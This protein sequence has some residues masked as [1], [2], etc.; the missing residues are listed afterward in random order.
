MPF[1]RLLLPLI[2]GIL[3]AVFLK[4]DMGLFVVC[5][6]LG[7]VGMLF[8]LNVNDFRIS[9]RLKYFQA[10]LVF[11]M[12]LGAG[13]MLTLES[14]SKDNPQHFAQ[15]NDGQWMIGVLEESLTEKKRSFRTVLSIKQVKSMGEWRPALGN[16]LVYLSKDSLAGNLERGDKLLVQAK[17]TELEEPANP[18]EFN[19]KRF[20][21]FR[22]IYH[23]QFIKS[24]GWM[25]LEK[26]PNIFTYAERA[27]TLL[28]AQLKNEGLGDDEMAIASALLLGKKDQLSAE[29]MHAYAGAG[30]MHVLAVSGLHMGI[31]F[32]F[33]SKVLK[34][35]RQLPRGV[36]IE[37]VLILIVMWGFAFITG[38]SPS[39]VRASTMFTAIAMARL[40]KRTSDIYN[41]IAA[42]AFVLLLFNPFYI[43][44]VG[45]QLSYLA[46]VGIIYLQPKLK[47]L[48]FFKSKLPTL[49]WEITCVSLAAQIATFPLGLLYFHQFPTYFLFSN[50]L[51]I[52]AAYLILV[53]GFSYFLTFWIPY[54]GAAIAFG[55]K[56][57]IVALNESVIFLENLPSALISGIDISILETW[58]IYSLIILLSM[59]IIKRK[60][61]L[62]I[63][64]IACVLGL[65]VV[66]F[67]ETYSF[68]RHEFLTVYDVNKSSVVNI[69]SDQANHVITDSLLAADMDK[70]QFHLRN[71]WN[72]HG[73]P[74]PR[75]SELREVV[76]GLY[77]Y[78]GK[79]IAII[80]SWS[81]LPKLK[82]PIE[83]DYL[84]IS[85]FRGVKMDAILSSYTGRKIIIDSTVREKKANLLMAGLESEADVHAVVF[86]GFFRDRL[87]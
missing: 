86:D 56:W 63:T 75:F 67:Y 11:I 58:L 27:R 2:L 44:E 31:L 20:L 68:K 59:A 16:M 77:D 45:F 35:L 22:D 49:I 70:Q 62:L 52:P 81:D 57:L 61:K 6:I 48:L 23:Q 83:V 14:V 30:A 60:K 36:I 10:P 65:L 39:V 32:L 33:L 7:F 13:G 71:N 64:S 79:S 24:G 84:V 41:T 15:I 66:Q 5:I 1:V 34:V 80:D 29:L 26:N 37:T 38:M 54:L 72:K 21:S 85:Y 18:G 8:L 74:E 3:S 17:L 82:E 42:S 19:Y 4:V 46:V 87:H 28:I 12:I 43:M 25:L 55:L 47:S 40:F 69:L 9:F 51:V 53:F 76:P 73:A 50:L 78:H